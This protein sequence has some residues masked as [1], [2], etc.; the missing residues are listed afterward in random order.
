MNFYKTIRRPQIIF[1]VIIVVLVSLFLLWLP[2]AAQQPTPAGSLSAITLSGTIDSVNLPFIL[3]NG[4]LVNVEGLDI[5][6]DR[7][8]VGLA[9]TVSGSLQNG[10][11][12]AAALGF[13][14]DDDDDL[15]QTVT[16]TVIVTPSP[17]APTAAPPTAT[18]TGD[19]DDD[20]HNPRII[21]EGPVTQIT[22]N[23]IVI[24][25]LNITINQTINITNIQLGDIV[26]VE[27][28][29]VIVN[30]IINIVAVNVI[31]ISLERRHDFRDSR[32]SG[33]RTLGDPRPD[34]SRD[35]DRRFDSPPPPPPPSSGRSSRSS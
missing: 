8:Q 13:D 15:L 30:N 18:P 34:D 14:D 1:I 33:R 19:D 3:V 4:L 5:P 23:A 25:N 32:G 12:Q 10:I 6:S 31:N 22:V 28:D 20:D 35:S 9:V 7:L 24:F 27:G 29:L 11:I 17:A 16:P 26:R 21:I 2:T